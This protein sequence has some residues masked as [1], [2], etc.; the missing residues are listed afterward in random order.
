MKRGMASIPALARTRTDTQWLASGES[1]H[2]DP[3]QAGV[4]AATQALTGDDAKL[5]VVFA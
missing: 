4:E 1:H 5:L 3:R 2:P